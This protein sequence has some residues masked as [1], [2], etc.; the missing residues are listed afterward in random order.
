MKQT[1]KGLQLQVM[2][3]SGIAHASQV[4]HEMAS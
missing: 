3:V 1:S 2:H 4:F